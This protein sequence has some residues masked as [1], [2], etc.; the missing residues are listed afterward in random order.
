[1]KYIAHFLIVFS[2]LNNDV[3]AGVMPSRTRVV[4]TESNREQSLM[5]ANTNSYPVI[6]QT[7]I[8]NGEGT[9]D[10]S[11]IPFVSVPPVFRLEPH[12]VKGV[13]IIY[14][15]RPVRRDTESLYWF[16]IYEI[17]PERKD[18]VKVN[19][20]LVTMNTQIKL[21]YRP[22]GVVTTPEQAISAVTCH[23]TGVK[24]MQCYNPSPIHISVIAVQVDSEHLTARAL[25][26]DLMMS[27][28]GEKKINLSKDI[29]DSFSA[30]FHYINDSGDQLTHRIVVKK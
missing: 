28:S 10:V 23:R 1:M 27:P 15:G 22:S 19:S 14:N 30:E 17:P 26:S 25:D 21:F 5:L 12:A 8:D 18:T 9:P 7:W 2:L 4:Y 16:N 29:P 11:G 24:I 13:R 20:V 3:S 6:V